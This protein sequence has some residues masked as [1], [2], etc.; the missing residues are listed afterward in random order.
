MSILFG[1]F[2]SSARGATAALFACVALAGI[3]MAAE[4]DD[5]LRV[6][7]TSLPWLVV[8]DDVMGG[9]SRSRIAAEE[10]VLQ[11]RGDLSLANNGGFA[12]IRSRGIGSLDLA[13]AAALQLRVRG[14]GR[15]YQLRAYSDARFRGREV[16]YV[17]DFDTVAGEWIEV[18]IPIAGMPPRFRGMD[19]RGPALESA[20]IS[21]L[22]VMLAD[23]REGSFALE[24][25]WIGGAR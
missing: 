14:D 10:G 24:I 15:T 12:S 9:I 2:R 4:P 25:D 16:A 19:L 18:S 6:S 5:A 8:N 13:G 20:D 22:G 7:A 23:K 1:C 3:A 17:G 21:G 11:F